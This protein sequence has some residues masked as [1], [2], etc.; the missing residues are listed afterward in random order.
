[1]SIKLKKTEIDFSDLEVQNNEIEEEPTKEEEPIKELVTDE[2]I[3]KEIKEY[4]PPL[5]VNTPERRNKLM[6]INRYFN[7]YPS[8]LAQ[9]KQVVEPNLNIMS[10]SQLDTVLDEIRMI[11]GGGD[12]GFNEQIAKFGY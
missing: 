1:M 6:F 4:V 5:P 2:D 9:I 11:R 8:Q 12:G 3:N 10:D 7:K